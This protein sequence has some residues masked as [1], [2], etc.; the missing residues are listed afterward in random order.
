MIDPLQSYSVAKAADILGITRKTVYD[1][2]RAGDLGHWKINPRKR[3]SGIRITHA[4][5]ERWLRERG[6]TTSA[7]GSGS[8]RKARAG[9]S[10]AEAK[11]IGAALSG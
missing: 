10:I 9:L 7:T 5:I 1:L 11:S 2:I 6:A 3:R 8:E 4:E